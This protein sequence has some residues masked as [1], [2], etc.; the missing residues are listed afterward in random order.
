M[1]QITVFGLRKELTAF[2]EPSLGHEAA[3]T[4]RGLLATEWGWSLTDMALRQQEAVPDDEAGR[5]RQMA[6]RLAAHEPLQYVC[7]QCFFCGLRLSVG[8]GALIPRPETEQLVELIDQWAG[9]R[10]GLRVLD[11]GTGSGCIALALGHGLEGAKVSAIDFSAQAVEMAR[12]NADGTGVRVWRQDVMTASPA[13]LGEYD[14]VV[15]NP[16]YVRLS[17]REGMEAN[18]LDHEPESALFVPDDDPLVFYRRIASLCVSGLLA[19][20]GGLFFEINEALGRETADTMRA[21]GLRGVEVRK[22]YLGK[23]RFALGFL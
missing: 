2:L 9:G 12:A 14:I 17:E 15:S 1:S 4:V 8:P 7:G 23:D 18:V 3:P 11:I 10:G 20:G 16:P 21:A 6:K 19:E 13:E 22:D 5:L